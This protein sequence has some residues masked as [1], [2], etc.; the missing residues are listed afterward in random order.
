MK[1][2]AT[3]WRM[4]NRAV[5]LQLFENLARNLKNACAKNWR[6]NGCQISRNVYEASVPSPVV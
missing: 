1:I 2:L 4:I 6:K 3:P 5:A